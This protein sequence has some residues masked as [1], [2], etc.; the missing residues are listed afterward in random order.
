MNHTEQ[1]D[2]SRAP[3]T[4]EF[5]PR[6]LPLP[7]ERLLPNGI[8]RL[9]LHRPDYGFLRLDIVCPGGS[10][11]YPPSVATAFGRMLKEGSKNFNGTEIAELLDFNGASVVAAPS[12]HHTVVSLTALRRNISK[13]LP[14]FFDLLQNPLFPEKELQTLKRQMI[15]E[16]QCN[17]E[18]PSFHAREEIRRLVSGPGHR[19]AR[20]ESE[21]GIRHISTDTLERCHRMSIAP[22]RM[23]AHAAGSAD[24]ELLAE[25]DLYLQ[26]IENLA[27]TPGQEHIHFKPEAAGIYK[28]Q[29][30][31]SLQHAVAAAVPMPE[32]KPSD[33]DYW[34]L[35]FAIHALGGYFGSRL[36]Q[37]IR[38]DKG[39][40]YGIY[41]QYNSLLPEGTFA[42]ISC[43]CDPAYTDGVLS[44]IKA[45]LVK[46]AETP[47]N[48]DEHR[49]LR[50]SMAS[51]L[52]GICDT[53]AKVQAQYISQQ[54]N[55]QGENF[56][57]L[58]WKALYEVTPAQMS[59]AAARFLNPEELRVA[60]AGDFSK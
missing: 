11:E 15:T 14:V 27:D 32:L 51:S 34:P 6:K 36:M 3:E 19:F 33:K 42:S 39:Y 43:E 45:E 57:D 60:I 29:V 12:N 4:G 1:P 35:R 5:Q 41:A 2:R 37:N 13:V 59:E 7:E 20:Q 25:I 28:V 54:I 38:E 55:G 9:A 58:Y 40:T 17:R 47:M 48:D 18:T 30:N 50:L 23:S 44:E 49:I 46:F 52:A 31:D 22:A 56:Y 10:M 8:R 53:P 24:K 21:D 16:L 26:G